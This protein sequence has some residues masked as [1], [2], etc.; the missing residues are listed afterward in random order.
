MSS[1]TPATTS[2]TTTS[3]RDPETGGTDTRTE[4]TEKEQQMSTY[5]LLYY[6]RGLAS[7]QNLSG[8]ILRSANLRCRQYSH[9]LYTG[10]WSNLV[11]FSK[12]LYCLHLG[13]LLICLIA[14]CSKSVQIRG[15][16]AQGASWIHGDTGSYFTYGN[17]AKGKIRENSLSIRL[18]SQFLS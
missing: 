18:I 9:L 12:L 11:L 2:S 17:A 15:L 14:K 4:T 16:G 6:R 13:M 7:S 8:S 1:L 5:L 3:T 10:H